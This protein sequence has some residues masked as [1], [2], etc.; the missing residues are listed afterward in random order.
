ML[1]EA[2]RRA[3]LR[4][5]TLDSL[6]GRRVHETFEYLPGQRVDCED[7]HRLPLADEARHFAAPIYELPVGRVS[8]CSGLLYYTYL[9]SILADRWTLLLD[10]NNAYQEYPLEQLAE[11][12]YWRPRFL[13]QAVPV[14][15]HAFAFRSASNNYYHTLVDNLPRLLALHH[16]RLSA[17]PIQLLVPSELQPF[18]RFFLQRLLPP[19][20]RVRVLEGGQLFRP[21]TL[22]LPT[23]LSRQM[24][25]Y[26]PRG[27]LDFFLPRVLPDRPRK[28]HRRIYITRRASR[29]GRR[30]L[31]EAELLSVLARHG[32]ESHALESMSI[33][34]Q[35]ELFYD[36]ELVVAPHG[37][38]LTNLLFAE[39]ADVIELH[40]APKIM[41]HYFFLSRALGHRYAYVCGDAPHRHSDFG[42][43]VPQ[44]SRLLEQAVP[45]P[46]R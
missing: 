4:T 2:L 14:A 39:R 28:R 23:F 27:W 19:N 45:A 41:P 43:D 22:V 32:V 42:V 37:A 35:I 30:I 16:P 33:E 24:S 15:G 40:P 34:A 11:V 18:E 9:N 20:V 44:V 3:A 8:L 38:G 25:G 6:G 29:V 46:V 1:R 10:A 26:L 31:N 13:R 17:V 21:E 7:A 36:A 12:F 5:A